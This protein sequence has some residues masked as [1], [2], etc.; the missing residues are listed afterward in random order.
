MPQM[1]HDGVERFDTRAIELL[2]ARTILTVAVELLLV[3]MTV[4]ST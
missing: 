1:H 3:Y 4:D 2:A